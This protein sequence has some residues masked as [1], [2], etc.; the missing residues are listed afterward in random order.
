MLSAIFERI[1]AGDVDGVRELLQRDPA[2]AAARD[3][4]GVSAVRR[5]AYRDRAL[6]DVLLAARPPLDSFDAALVGD[7]ERLAAPDEWSEDGFTPLHLAAFGGQAEA[8]R[9][10]LERGA[11]ADAMSRHAQIKVRPLHT[12]A[13]VG[14]NDVARVLLERGADPNGRAEEIANTALHSAA[15]NGNAQL[16]RLLLE[17]GADPNAPAADGR[18]PAELAADEETAALLRG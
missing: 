9:V 7:L 15:Q 16:V 1:D 17:F 4:D 3:A 5:A 11:D 12:A 10:L 18:T 2:A 6:L 14:A 8:A 13:F